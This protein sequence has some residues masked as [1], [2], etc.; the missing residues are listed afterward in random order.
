MHTH[1]N[2]IEYTKKIVPRTTPKEHSVRSKLVAMN[3][4]DIP[5]LEGIPGSRREEPSGRCTFATLF[6]S[7]DR[8]AFKTAAIRNERNFGL[9][10][11]L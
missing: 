8:P 10:G 2:R 5:W 3:P 4:S 7:L 11:E 9:V 6:R 1:I